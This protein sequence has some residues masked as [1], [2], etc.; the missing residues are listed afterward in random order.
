MMKVVL[1]V[2]YLPTTSACSAV[3]S[4]FIDLYRATFSAFDQLYNGALCQQTD[5]SDLNIQ[6]IC[7]DRSARRRR[8]ATLSSTQVIV[9]LDSAP[10]T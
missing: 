10:S 6:I 9:T 2:N 3:R 7:S 4:A 1:R 5:C 8:Q